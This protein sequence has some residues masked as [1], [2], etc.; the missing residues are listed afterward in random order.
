MDTCADY[1]NIE[2]FP[3]FEDR[4]ADKWNELIK[5][6][7]EDANV[8]SR[9]LSVKHDAEFVDP[10]K[11]LVDQLKSKPGGQIVE[12]KGTVADKTISL[13]LL[14]LPSEQWVLISFTEV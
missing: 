4:A 10:E 9:A 8:E 3:K 11:I 12:M 1:V 7:Q 13:G 5:G 14:E 6:V 2:N